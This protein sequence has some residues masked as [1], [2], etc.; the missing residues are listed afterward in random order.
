MIRFLVAIIAG[1]ATIMPGRA[2][3]AQPP[4]ISVLTYHRLDPTTAA[5]ATVV[6]T[7][8]FAEQMAWLD[9]HHI[10]VVPLRAVVALVRGAG[11]GDAPAVAITA[12]DGFR[13]VYTEMF[14]IIRRYRFPLT[15][16]INPPAI[17][18]GPAYLT[19]AEIADMVASGLVDVEPHT[20][21]HPDFRR[22]RAR[23]SPADYQ[24]FVAREL[25]GGRADVV[26]RLGT[27]ADLL[28][29]PYGIHDADLEAAAARAGYGAAFALGSRPAQS[30]ADIF[31]I[32][33]YQIYNSDRGA[34]FAAIVAGL[35]RGGAGR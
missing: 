25:D 2:P 33:R 5:H 14:P 13:S 12:D 27:A 35:Q 6:L 34:R 26:A 9:A 1:V 15:L 23:R 4:A 24:A 28:A 16:F 21:T 7:S 22:E 32:P 3:A 8:V 10:A 18:D 29:W 31:A 30:G 11:S 17:S 19:C 20:L